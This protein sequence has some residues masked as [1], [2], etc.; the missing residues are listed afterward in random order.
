MFITSEYLFILFEI[1][2]KLLCSFVFLDKTFNYECLMNALLDKYLVKIKT[3]PN[4]RYKSWEHCFYAFGKHKAETDLLCLHLAFY[5]ASWGM[6]R[7]SCG[8]LQ[9]DYLVHKEA[10]NILKQSK[11]YKLSKHDVHIEDIPIIIE[12][13]DELINYYKTIEYIDSKEE[14][15]ALSVTDTLLSKIMLGTLGCTP[16]FD[17]YFLSG[18]KELK[19][20]I[21][22]LNTKSFEYIFHFIKNH[23]MNEVQNELMKQG[24]KYPIMKIVDMYLWEIGFETKNN[25][26]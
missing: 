7:G 25:S 5:L 24:F 12:L 22:G 20:R 18:A 16:A 21:R 23:K 26:N 9:K 11:F 15:K 13:K 1:Q 14:V 17:R 10:I 8:L 2:Q 3:D 4:H 6:M 19:V